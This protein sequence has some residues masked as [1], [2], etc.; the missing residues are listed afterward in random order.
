M[1]NFTRMF[2]LDTARPANPDEVTIVKD[3]VPQVITTHLSIVRCDKCL[4]LV[5]EKDTEGHAEWHY[6][7][8]MVT[9][10]GWG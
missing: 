1:L 6:R 9:G 3:G 4:A 8:S 5:E 7:M 10:Y 2:E